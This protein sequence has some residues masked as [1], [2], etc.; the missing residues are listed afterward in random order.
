ML[1]LLTAIIAL[2]SFTPLGY[3]RVGFVEITL[4]MIPVV[5]GAII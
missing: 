5:I 1:S 4:I 3:L 2:F